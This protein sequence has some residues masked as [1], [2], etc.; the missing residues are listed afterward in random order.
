MATNKV[1]STIKQLYSLTKKGEGPTLEF[2]KT[3]AKLKEAMQTICAFLNGSG[4]M[5]LLGIGPDN[6]IDGQE[7]S[8][9]T[10]REIAQ[11][12]ERFE[13]P[14]KISVNRVKVKNNREV[15]IIS[16]TGALDTIPFTFESRPYERVSS[17]TKKMPQS[18]YEKL[19]LDRAHAHRRWENQTA[20]DV[21][22]SELDREEILIMREEAI[23]QR[24]I[25]AGTSRNIGEILDRIGLRSNGILTQAAHVL[26]GKRYLP[27]YPQC[28]IKMGRFRGTTVLGDILDNRQEHINAFA[29]IREGMA[30]LDRTLPLAAHFPE[31]KINRE[32]RLPVPPNALREILLNAIM[33][34]DYSDPG[35][36]VAIAVFD[37]RIEIRSSGTL[38]TGITINMLSKPHLSFVQTQKSNDRRSLS[39][40]WSCGNMGPRNK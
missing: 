29:M 31:G 30:F 13:P 23:R 6:T 25:S 8:D 3:T 21:K 15:I 18:K 14:A 27:N 5:V 10:L 40:Y 12:T 9:Q 4:G 7:V 17:T 39:S 22:L 19:L 1:P 33:H 36:F 11:V 16:V 24:R 26:F 34:R 20:V 37:D 28:M 2:K 32:D 35:G 38:P